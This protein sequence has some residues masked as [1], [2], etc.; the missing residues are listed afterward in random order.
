MRTKT[1]LLTAVLSVAGLLSAAAQVYSVNVV[2]YINVTAPAGFSIIANQLD[3]GKGNNL[4]DL[5]PTAPAGTQVFKYTG[6]GYDILTFDDLD[7]AWL[8]ATANIILAPGDAAFIKNPGTTSMTITFVGEVQQGTL[9]INLPAGYSMV[10]SK[11]PQ[12]A[13]VTTLGIVGQAGD[14]ILRYVNGQYAI[15]TYDD[16]DN[17]WLPAPEPT[18]KVGEGFWI[19]KNA[20]G[21]WTRVFNVN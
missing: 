7:N 11:V 1:L 10:S 20:A 2:G 4:R 14:Q 21:T 15:S 5:M 18:I 19:K 16:L 9:T 17:A 12:E 3:N 6:A 13:T 8:P